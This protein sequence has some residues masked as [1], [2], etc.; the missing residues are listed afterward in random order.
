MTIYKLS[1]EMILKYKNKYGENVCGANVLD[2][3]GFNKSTIEKL[4]EFRGIDFEW[5]DMLDVIN[6]NDS[7][8]KSKKWLIDKIKTTKMVL[9]YDKRDK[10]SNKYNIQ[11]IADELQNGTYKI[12]GIATETWG[13]YMVLGKN[14]KGDILTYDPQDQRLVVG[15]DDIIKDFDE[16][17]LEYIIS[18][19]NGLIID[20]N[21]GSIKKKPRKKTR[22][23]PRK[24][25]VKTT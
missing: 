19:S 9:N 20:R 11:F 14:S 3:F 2:L 5:D 25:L 1:D 17:D 8:I 12:I 16:D 15:I 7:K 21:K 18:Y 6:E 4:L 13:H 23:K 22:K 10:Q 24:K